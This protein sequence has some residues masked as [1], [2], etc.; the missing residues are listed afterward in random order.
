MEYHQYNDYLLSNKSHSCLAVG[1]DVSLARITVGV[2][3]GVSMS[4]VV[5]LLPARARKY[6]ERRFHIAISLT[7]I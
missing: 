7:Y 3:D 2:A 4:V 6:P 5:A 1:L